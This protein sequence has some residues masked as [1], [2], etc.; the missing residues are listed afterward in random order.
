MRKG[1]C[2]PPSYVPFQRNHRYHPPGLL[3]ISSIRF[4]QFRVA[5]RAVA[6]KANLSRADAISS[7]LPT[8]RLNQVNI[9]AAGKSKLDRYF[10]TH[11]ETAFPNPRPNS[12]NQI[13]GRAAKL[14]VHG[15]NRFR[16]DFR[17]YS[18]PSG[19]NRSHCAVS[20]IGN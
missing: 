16:R 10:R 19:V 4:E 1:V 18:A 7:Q 11:F 9:R 8:H 14:R 13:L 17:H 6:A 12:H 5:N 15:L 3:P 2:L 20:R